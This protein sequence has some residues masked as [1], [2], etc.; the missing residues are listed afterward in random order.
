MMVLMLIGASQSM[1]DSS[2]GYAM[3][4]E[5]CVNKISKRTAK[6]KCADLLRTHSAMPAARIAPRSS[7]GFSLS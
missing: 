3:L 6:L 5:L 4:F 1:G 7:P 2:W